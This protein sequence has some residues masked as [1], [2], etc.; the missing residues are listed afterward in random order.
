MGPAGR[1][2]TVVIG[3]APND[4]ACARHAG[5]QAIAIAHRISRNELERHSPDAALDRLDTDTVLSTV[6][7]VIERSVTD[8]VDT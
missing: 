6:T 8:V 3:D 1:S 4:I 5:F 7:G 2:R